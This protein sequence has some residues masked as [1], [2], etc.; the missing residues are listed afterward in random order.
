[1]SDGVDLPLFAAGQLL[2]LPYRIGSEARVGLEGVEN[3]ATA[4]SSPQVQATLP[5]GRIAPGTATRRCAR[6]STVIASEE[7]AEVK[8]ELLLVGKED[9]RVWGKSLLLSLGLR[10]DDGVELSNQVGGLNSPLIEALS[11]WDPDQ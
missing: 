9:Q 3:L 6:L 2:I 8:E 4:C 1:M 5:K 10:V 11:L 7:S